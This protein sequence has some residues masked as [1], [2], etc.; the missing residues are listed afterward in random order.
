MAS[1]TRLLQERM[2]KKLFFQQIERIA[3]TTNQLIM[4]KWIDLRRTLLLVD[5]DRRN[6]RPE[7]V[8]VIQ[9]RRTPHCQIVLYPHNVKDYIMVPC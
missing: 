6:L 3:R 5:F 8:S 2:Q 7:M 4:Y 1:S 9:R